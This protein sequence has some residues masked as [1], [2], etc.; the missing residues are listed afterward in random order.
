MV[1]YFFCCTFY[2]VYN[3]FLWYIKKYISFSYLG[4]V[5]TTPICR[6]QMRKRWN[7]RNVES[8]KSYLRHNTHTPHVPKRIPDLTPRW[9]FHA[10]IPFTL[11]LPPITFIPLYHCYLY[12]LMCCISETAFI[13]LCSILFI[14]LKKVIF[15][16]NLNCTTYFH[17]P[18]TSL[19]QGKQC[20]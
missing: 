19:T 10:L 7:K 12:I 8:L 3:N 15:F 20:S 13:F 9:S 6:E 14:F 17:S 4:H 5:P 2:L 16:K 11:C 1:Q 18:Q